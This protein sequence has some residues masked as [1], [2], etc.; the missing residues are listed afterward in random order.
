MIRGRIGNAPF[1]PATL[2]K[3]ICA[4]VRFQ[5]RNRLEIFLFSTTE[6]SILFPPTN[7]KQK[8]QTSRGRNNSIA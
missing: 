1:S 6:K 8:K 4:G 2:R 3:I 5:L 7:Y